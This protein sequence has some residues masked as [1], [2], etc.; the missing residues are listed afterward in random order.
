[1][2]T[3]TDVA[4]LRA[5]IHR[6]RA[7][8]KRIGLVPTMGNLHAGHLQLAQTALA[9]TDF[10]LVTIFVN[11][12]QFGPTEDLDA[13]PRTLQQDQEALQQAG[14]HALFAPSV[15]EIYGGD[16]QQQTTVH[17][18]GVSEGYCGA[19]RPGHFD[20]V[21]TIVCKLFNLIAP[22]QAFFG[23]KDYQQFLVIRKMVAD[24]GLPIAVV[25]VDIVRADSGLA[26]SSRNNYLSPA[27]QQTAAN[28]YQCLLDTA[29]AINAGNSDF[30]ELE[31]AARSRL[32]ALGLQPDYFSVAEATS[33]RP[34]GPGDTHLVI[35]AAAYVGTTRLIDNLLVDRQVNSQ[36]NQGR[37][38]HWPSLL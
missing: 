10:V 19:S 38:V 23:L 31:A 26:L 20:G 33:L 6:Q 25:G 15:E 30:K 11:P 18:P 21:A 9:R 16:L 4:S 29:S 27:Q 7:A 37:S 35:L 22:D 17:V 3:F 28:L 14:C 5:E 32:S 2:H 24:L 1:M 34:A 8:G 13:Y 36:G 12:L